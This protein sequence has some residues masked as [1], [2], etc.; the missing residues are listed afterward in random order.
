MTPLKSVSFARPVVPKPRLSAPYVPGKR[1]HRYW[2]AAE[3]AVLRERYPDG[4]IAACQP[5][6]PAHHATPS[7]IYQR[8]QKLGLTK[9]GVSRPQRIVVDDGFDDRLRA[10]WAMLDGRKKGEVG[11]LADRLNV[12]RYWLTNRATKLGLTIAHKKEPRWTAAEDELMKSIPLHNPDSCARIF[13]QHGF[14]RSPTAIMVRA[15]RLDLS[16]RATRDELSAT[17]AAKILGVDGKWITAACIAGELAATKRDDRRLPQQG[18][19]AWDIRRA[20]LRRFILDHLERI[21]LRKVEKFA[22]VE[23]IATGDEP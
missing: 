16:R 10:E 4:G 13:K 1:H 22:F 17:G 19:S 3:D 11:D 9:S 23:L 2:T 5:H 15:K 6:L 8:A 21:D 20:D 14:A 7:G 12:P 18:G